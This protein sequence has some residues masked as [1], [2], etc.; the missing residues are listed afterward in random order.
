MVIDGNIGGSVLS[1]L[2]TENKL[3]LLYLIYLYTMNKDPEKGETW[4]KENALLSL[5]H[6]LIEKNVL[7]YDY[8][9]QLVLWGDKTRIANMSTQLIQELNELRLTHV[10][11]MRVATTDYRYLK[12]YRITNSGVEAL[13]KIPDEVKNAVRQALSCPNCNSLLEIK[14]NEENLEPFLFCKNCNLK[15]KIGLLDIGD[16]SYEVKS[17]KLRDFLDDI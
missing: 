16:Y 5:A 17:F 3:K 10:A 6:Y 15:I 8:A 9:P 14:F 12:A 11:Q 1:I 13:S 7:D 4:I 2:L